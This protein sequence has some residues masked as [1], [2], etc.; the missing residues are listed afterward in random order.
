[1]K[2]AKDILK[3]F[4]NIH[5]ISYKT[6]HIIPI[7][8]SLGL[9]LATKIIPIREGFDY[10]GI[11]NTIGVLTAFYLFGMEKID[12]A[13]MMKRFTAESKPM[14]LSGKVYKQ[15]VRMVYTYYSLLL[16]EVFLIGIQYTL[17][18]F[19]YEYTTLLFLSICYML[20]AI[21][22]AILC[23]HGYLFMRN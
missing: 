20:T 22:F 10:I 7:L 5:V 1:M 23:W 15:G 16:I 21:T 11:L 6:L 13:D 17:Y 9:A 14:F 19:G 4:M 18:L 8:I 3:N 2:I 12:L